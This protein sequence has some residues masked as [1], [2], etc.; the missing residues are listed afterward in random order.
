MSDDVRDDDS[1]DD[2]KEGD[3]DYVE[4]REGDSDKAEDV[5]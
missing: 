3:G 1:N 4:P 5:A 2:G